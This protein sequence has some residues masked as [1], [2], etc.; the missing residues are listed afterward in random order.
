MHAETGGVTR[1]KSA[2]L[3]PF[4]RASEAI[5]FLWNYEMLSG[6]SVFSTTCPSMT[7]T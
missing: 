1:I 4:P 2:R 7:L 3:R 5:F 6:S